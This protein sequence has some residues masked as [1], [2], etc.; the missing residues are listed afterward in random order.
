[1]DRIASHDPIKQIES[2]LKSLGLTNA[3]DK[4]DGIT[5][6]KDLLSKLLSEESKALESGEASN[7]STTI[8]YD[9][10][11]KEQDNNL[12]DKIERRKDKFESSYS[13]EEEEEME[14]IFEEKN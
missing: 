8:N 7:N 9:E 1:M 12:P 10:W 3:K 5:S 11:K 13:A 6:E 2:L 14:E 4:V